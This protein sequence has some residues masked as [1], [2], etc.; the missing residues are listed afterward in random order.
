MSKNFK[1]VCNMLTRKAALAGIALSA[2]I[3]SE[4]L[5]QSRG[6]RG[7]GHDSGTSH[8]H[9]SGHSGQG[10]RSS[11]RAGR[12]LD[13][14]GRGPSSLR[15]VF[16]QL[17]GETAIVELRGQRGGQG[18]SSATSRGQRGGRNN[19]VG[20]TAADEP[21]DG[22]RPYWAGSSGRGGGGAA[23]TGDLYGDLYVIERDENGVPILAAPKDADGEV[24]E[25]VPDQLQV[26]YVDNGELTCCVPYAVVD[27][28]LELVSTYSPAEAVFSRTSVVRSPDR[29]LE[30][31]YAEFVTMVNS[32]DMV[33]IT[34][35]DTDRLILNWTDGTTTSIDSPL[36][37]LALYEKILT[38]G[39]LPD[40]TLRSGD[41]VA[42]DLSKLPTELA[43]LADTSY[44]IDDLKLTATYLAA[45]MDK[46]GTATVD[47]VVYLNAI[48]DVATDTN[49]VSG[50]AEYVK[51]TD[52]SDSDFV[53]TYDRTATYADDP[54][55]PEIENSITIQVEDPN[56]PGTWVTT[57]VNIL[58]QVFG[59][60][61]VSVTDG[62][63]AY[64]QAVDDARAVIDYLH[65]YAPP[66]SK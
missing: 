42:V 6:S 25:N 45:A 1:H 16:R 14:G 13:M 53:F 4:A 46:S 29:V 50:S 49:S 5:G 34:L 39:T 17:E 11:G 62:I 43:S 8:D 12:N 30:S 57:T 24:I 44:S 10:G 47:M 9:A 56:N 32:E 23:G 41:T 54:S 15:G 61:A 59:G 2:L 38:T 40:A 60:E 48:L 51:F 31:Q 27:G 33:S 21:T 28:D 18:G 22:S 35:D 36:I 66:E 58:D 64:T 7:G 37:Y 63:E 52:P 20:D 26:Y 19:E 3:A 65:T 55:T